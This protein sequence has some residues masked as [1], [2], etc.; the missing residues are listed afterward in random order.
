MRIVVTLLALA[1]VAPA[2]GGEDAPTPAPS[3]A[4]VTPAANTAAPTTGA[5]AAKPKTLEGTVAQRLDASQYSYLEIATADGKVWAAVPQVDVADGAKVTVVDPM[6]MTNFESKALERTFEQVYFGR[7]STQGGGAAGAM[8]MGGGKMAPHGAKGGDPHAGIPGA[9]PVGMGKP[10]PSQVDVDQ[11]MAAHGKPAAAREDVDVEKAEGGLTIA[12]VWAKR[13][14]LKDQQV[15]VRGKVVK[16]NG[17]IMG[18]NWLH[19]QDGSGDPANATHDLTVTSKDTAT[20]GDV[21]TITGKLQLDQEFG[22]G[23][24]YETIVQEATVTQK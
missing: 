24:S 4:P 13:G 16:Y 17:N 20:V 5:V 14:E 1:L 12:E 22:A 8:G 11:A 10:A 18:R 23:Y 3:P 9:P 19:I 15:T 6:L 21:V 2:C 7:L